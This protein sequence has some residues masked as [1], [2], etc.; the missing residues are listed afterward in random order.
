MTVLIGLTVASLFLATPQAIAQQHISWAATPALP[1]D[2]HAWVEG[3]AVSLQVPKAT[4]PTGT[5]TYR[6]QIKAAQG[7]SNID[8]FSVD[9]S[10]TA[11]NVINGTVPANSAGNWAEFYYIA[12]VTN[13][14]ITHK[15]ETT[16]DFVSYDDPALQTT[17]V[18]NQYYGKDVAI[19][20]LT[21][22]AVDTSGIYRKISYTLTPALPAGLSF[23]PA[24]PKITGTPTEILAQTEYT[25][26]V[27]DGS[28]TPSEN[29][30]QRSIAGQG[31]VSKSLKFKINVTLMPRNVTISDIT[32]TQVK[33]SWT[34]PSGYVHQ[35][36][37][38][39][40]KVDGTE[41]PRY[42]GGTSFGLLGLEAN[43]QYL[44]K[45]AAQLSQVPG[46][47][48]N[49]S[50]WVS[51]TTLSQS[52][53]AIPGLSSQELSQLSTLLTYDTLI[54]NEL[55]NG[56]DDTKDWLELRNV[57]ATAIALDTW[58]LNIRTNSGTVGVPFPAGTAI[59]P[60]EVLLLTNTEMATADAFIL[61]VVAETFVLP[62]ADFALTLRSPKVFGDLV[63]NYFQSEDERPETA[64]AFTV[65][66]VWD[67]TQPIVSGYRT[68][69]WAKSTYQ[70][71]LGSP[72][73]QPLTLSTD[74]NNDGT[75]NILDLVLVASQIGKSAAGNVADV[76]SDGTIDTSDLALVAAAF[77][78]LI[79]N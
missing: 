20:T 76:N 59:P 65:D 54:I 17:T 72:G 47:L 73:Y 48:G 41:Q 19:D 70:N 35:Y 18:G 25:F 13:N 26:T 63:G 58:Q 49:Y 14:N 15:I 34:A 42:V 10:D 44:L 45:V 68:E 27:T 4:A 57:S 37:V 39:F 11:H 24:T 7:Y 77:G 12:E 53:D 29:H 56:S 43:T 71:G 5:P 52:A 79:T 9:T 8:F 64:P 36:V 22:P 62:Q 16:V 30:L 78:T 31:T 3:H 6:L 75:V 66:T 1:S 51:F 38:Q 55:H 32:S 69:A 46:N 61:S 33:V 74:I 60:G 67:R 21:L 23:D 28:T 50:K 2:T 40:K